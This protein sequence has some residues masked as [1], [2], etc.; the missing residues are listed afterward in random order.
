[1]ADTKISELDASTVQANDELPIARSGSNYKITIQG[2]LD[3]TAINGVL[4]P[5]G[6]T[7]TQGTGGTIGVNGL[8]G[9]QGP[10]GAGTIAGSDGQLI[11]NDGGSAYSGIQTVFFDD[12]TETL[13]ISGNVIITGNN[14]DVPVLSTAASITVAD[15]AAGKMI[16]VDSSGG[17]KTITFANA[18]ANGFAISVVR[19]GSGNVIIANLALKSNSTIYTTSNIGVDNGV[20]TILYKATNEIVLIG[21]IEGSLSAIQ[22]AQGTSGTGTQGTQGTSATGTQGTQGISGAGASVGGS[23]TELQFNNAGSFD[24]ISSL[25]Y[26][27]ANDTLVAAAA[28]NVHLLGNVVDTP[29]LET[30]SD[31]TVA[32]NAAG[33]VIVVN[34]SGGDKTITFANAGVPGFAIAV[35]R[36]GTGNVLIAN[37]ALKSNS[38]THLSSNVAAN[39]TAVVVYTAT[40]RIYVFGDVEKTIDTIQGTTGETGLQGLIGVQGVQGRQGPTGTGATGL[41]GIQGITGD[42]GA[43]GS[44]G[45]T[46]LQGIQGISGAGTAGGSTTQVQFNNAGSFDG[47][48]N[49][50]FNLT[51]NTFAVGTDL[52]VAN[53]TQNTVVI[54]PGDAESD[55]A[56]KVYSEDV[57]DPS[58][59]LTFKV[60]HFVTGEKQNSCVE[61]YLGDKPYTDTTMPM[62]AMLR[63]DRYDGGSFINCNPMISVPSWGYR[64]GAYWMMREPGVSTSR[65]WAMGTDIGGQ[66]GDFFIGVTPTVDASSLNAVFYST[67]TGNVVI[68]DTNR[69]TV[70]G[71]VTDRKLTVEGTFAAINTT[72]L[73]SNTTSNVGIGVA[74]GVNPSAKLQ[75]VGSAN[76]DNAYISTINTAVW[77]NPSGGV[78]AD[79]ERAGITDGYSATDRY[80]VGYLV[81]PIREK[82]SGGTLTYQSPGSIWMAGAD[83]TI[84]HDDQGIEL[85]LGTTVS[86]YNNSGSVIQ[87]NVE[88]PAN[89]TMTLVGNGTTGNRSLDAF[90]MAT[91][92]KVGANNWLISGVDIT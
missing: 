28:A 91:V 43:A 19:S 51:S 68:P 92:I 23:A 33:K 39:S 37:T 50:T 65:S 40:N 20:A 8:Q 29:I 77:I 10:A 42:A 22:G 13:N 53:V 69:T 58:M 79:H 76:I 15:N 31:I 38:E 34:S 44:T 85:E 70:V 81:M 4:G 45:A 73:A 2:V 48:A 62:Q 9:V 11:Y 72:W 67:R 5:Q 27:T 25:N 75:V 56:L 26:Y 71:L 41:Q 32:E 17:D 80:P 57:S 54:G 18:A 74:L 21:D 46:G 3:Y 63:L 90:G 82:V 12:T 66:N 64:G 86:I 61:I 60:G 84:P 78:N 16:I 83:V 88:N 52:L 6:T 49:L 30:S 1:M 36:N 87:V 47:S 35:T 89:V 55:Y 14:I 24:G 7:G 59:N